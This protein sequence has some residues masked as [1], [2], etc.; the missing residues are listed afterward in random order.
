MLATK[1]KVADPDVQNRY[2]ILNTDL[3]R[4]LTI[5]T[6]ITDHPHFVN[7]FLSE[8]PAAAASCPIFL[9]KNAE[10]GEFYTAALFGFRKGE[11]LVEG[12]EEGRAAFRPL[13]L[14]RQG[15]YASDDNIAIDRSHPRFGPGA[16][17]RLFDEDG[18]PTDALR[19][20]QQAIGAVMAGSEA[21]K[22]FIR[23]ML[24]LKVIEPIDITLSFDDGENLT[25]DG[26]YTVSR[27]ALM[28]LDDATVVQLYRKWYIQAAWCMAFSLDQVGVLA[29]RRNERLA[30]GF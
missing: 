20:V 6:G 1:L 28:D 27:E 22:A 13:D 2:E 9:A 18:S 19:N 4:D 3:H 25:L 5:R 17:I 15:F 30:S 26:L 24:S 23:E 29:R 10:T 7:I 16:T 21:T 12:A 8:F 11:L 14:I